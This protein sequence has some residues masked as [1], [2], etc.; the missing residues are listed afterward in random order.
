MKPRKAT[1]FLNT[2]Y[3]N[4]STHRTKQKFHYFFS[5]ALLLRYCLHVAIGDGVVTVHFMA[6]TSH[7]KPP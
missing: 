5:G 6:I 1:R 4:I 2:T 3:K 7:L